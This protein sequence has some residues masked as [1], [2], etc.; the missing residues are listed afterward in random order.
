MIWYEY[1]FLNRGKPATHIEALSQMTK[2]EL[3]EYMPT[4]ISELIERANS[5]LRG[6]YDE[7]I[8]SQ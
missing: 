3:N 5:M 8:I 4:V 6:V 2:E 1:F 7:D